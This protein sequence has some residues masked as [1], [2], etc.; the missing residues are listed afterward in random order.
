MTFDVTTALI[1]G[2]AGAIA[3]GVAS[4]L[5]KFGMDRQKNEARD[6]AIVEFKADLAHKERLLMKFY[7]K[8][9]ILT[10]EH[11]TLHRRSVTVSETTEDSNVGELPSPPSRKKP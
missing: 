10:G 11:K 5:I 2:P 9:G 6:A 7:E 8:L 1:F 4:W 3:G